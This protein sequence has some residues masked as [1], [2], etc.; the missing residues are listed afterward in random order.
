MGAQ[1]SDIIIGAGIGGLSAALRLAHAGRKVTVLERHGA[2]GGK[3]RTLPSAFGP[4][5]AGPTVLTMRPVFEALFAD[6]GE[7]LSDHLTLTPQR[8]LA[9]HYWPDGTMLDLDADSAQSAANVE[10][11]FGTRAR[12]DFLRFSRRAQRLYDGFDAPMMQAAQPSSMQVAGRVLRD[13]GLARAMAPMRSLAGM[14]RQ[15]FAEPRLAQLFG[16]YATYVGGSPYASPAILGL[17]WHAEAQG[18]WR[19]EGGMHRLAATIARLA[20]ARG[21]EFHYGA[22]V[23]GIE[24]ASGRACTVRTATQTHQ[25]TS[26]LFNGDPNALRT[27]TL[28]QEARHAVPVRA[29]LPRSLSANVLAFAAKPEGPALAH[30]TVFFNSDPEAEFRA[31]ARGETYPDPT[32]YICAQDHGISAPPEGSQRFEIIMNAAPCP[33]DAPSSSQM[34][35]TTCLTIIRDTLSRHGLRLTPAPGADALTTPQM[36]N[37][38]FPQSH[39][40]LYGRSPH[41]MMAAFARPTARTRLPGLYLA[42]GGAHPGAGL[43]MATLSGRHAAEAIL[44]DRTSTS[45]SRPMVMPGGMSTASATMAPAPSRSSDS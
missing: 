13:P 31:L 5:D 16:R 25:A 37:H 23:T 17:I 32:L 34:D 39:G 29:T 2:P 14:L 27:G 35:Q 38:L 8:I 10:A 21:A 44:T 42:G 20:E 43:P 30:H 11:A 22:D 26:V 19:I 40:S 12:D 9:R 33:A 6:V 1:A 18:V 41:G 28:G 15:E 24:V 3:L 4:V 36:F 7:S 45:P